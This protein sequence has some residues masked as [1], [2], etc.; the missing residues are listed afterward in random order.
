M[1]MTHE[2]SAEYVV[3][4]AVSGRTA[5][6]YQP[7]TYSHLLEVAES[8]LGYQRNSVKIVYK[9]AVRSV[10]D[11]TSTPPAEAG[12]TTSN[13]SHDHTHTNYN[14]NSDEKDAQGLINWDLVGVLPTAPQASV[15]GVS[16]RPACSPTAAASPLPPPPPFS[17]DSAKGEE[18][19]ASKVI[20]VFGRPSR[21][22]VDA[23]PNAP[24]RARG[25]GQGGGL[26]LLPSSIGGS[27]LVMHSNSNSGGLMSPALVPGNVAPGFEGPLP[28]PHCPHGLQEMFTIANQVWGSDQNLSCYPWELYDHPTVQFIASEVSGDIGNLEKILKQIHASCPSLFQWISYY[29]RRFLRLINRERPGNEILALRHLAKEMTWES[30]NGSSWCLLQLQDGSNI[31]HVNIVLEVEG[32]VEENALDDDGDWLGISCDEES[33][34]FEFEVEE[35][36]LGSDGE[37]KNSTSEADESHTS[38]AA[39]CEP[40]MKPELVKPHGEIPLLRPDVSTDHM[41]G[42][43]EALKSVN[44]FTDV[45]H[46]EPYMDDVSSHEKDAPVSHPTSRLCSS[47]ESASR[48]A[49]AEVVYPTGLE[50]CHPS[51]TLSMPP[52]LGDIIQQSMES[53]ICQMLHLIDCYLSLDENQNLNDL[54]TFHS[55][56]Q[57]ISAQI[58][59]EI[60]T[61]LAS[62]ENV[63]GFNWITQ[64][65]GGVFFPRVEEFYLE[66][67]KHGVNGAVFGSNPDESLAA[68][69]C[70]AAIHQQLTCEAVRLAE[71]SHTEVAPPANDLKEEERQPKKNPLRAGALRN[72]PA[73]YFP[74]MNP[75]VRWISAAGPY[76]LL[77]ELLDTCARQG[78]SM[79]VWYS[80]HYAPSSS[81][82]GLRSVAYVLGGVAGVRARRLSITPAV[83]DDWRATTLRCLRVIRHASGGGGGVGD[84]IRA[85]W[86]RCMR[87]GYQHF[88]EPLQGLLPAS[89]PA[90]SGGVVYVIDTRLQPVPSN[91]ERFVAAS[92]IGL[93][94]WFGCLCDSQRITCMERWCVATSALP[95]KVQLAHEAF[96]YVFSDT[97][98]IAHVVALTSEE[99]GEEKGGSPSEW[100]S[101]GLREQLRVAQGPL[102]ASGITQS[103]AIVL[104]ESSWNHTGVARTS[105]P[106]ARIYRASISHNGLTPRLVGDLHVVDDCSGETGEVDPEE[107]LQRNLVDLYTYRATLLH[108]I[109]FPSPRNEDHGSFYKMFYDK[110]FN[111][112][113]MSLAAALRETNLERIRRHHAPW[114]GIEHALFDYGGPLESWGTAVHHAARRQYAEFHNIN[115]I[116]ERM[117][118]CLV[119]T[120]PR[121]EAA[122]LD[123]LIQYVESSQTELEHRENGGDSSTGP[124]IAVTLSNP[125]TQIRDYPELTQVRPVD[126]KTSTTAMGTTESRARFS[127]H[128]PVQAK[129][130]SGRRNARYT[131]K[132]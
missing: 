34:N 16:L 74:L 108:T 11:L 23:S 15:G 28:Y 27:T 92:G 87:V 48:A 80:S 131:K 9:G 8:Q 76:L 41:E 78:G 63:E 24:T 33:M 72:L 65:A 30:E 93:G 69:A 49:R 18:G 53:Q 117:L 45:H 3:L 79:I 59:D 60:S 40:V 99:G 81:G 129:M 128:P 127:P 25:R 84:T 115:S 122:V 12:G 83:Y 98:K 104:H 73:D 47:T 20:V 68:W 75:C 85:E 103:H 118:S 52:Q 17:P 90:S 105:G 10:A 26:H 46:G 62:P 35:A 61:D 82:E 97:D 121:S 91:D 77:Q 55:M 2:P 39:L 126:P 42:H 67:A 114:L 57:D 116:Y 31:H 50:K 14:D 64:K 36:N 120:R 51:K 7:H 70:K 58:M 71:L 5:R 96:P 132:K 123:Q 111:I 102:N 86:Q 106:E 101:S 124:T 54:R 66:L 89:P 100:L 130:K 1:P 125:T 6:L 19:V 13:R 44:A 56:L 107:V 119:A 32:N 22:K 113:S 112:P 94:I 37:A 95:W 21:R 43:P 38:E 4:R 88:V 110:L 29:P 109:A